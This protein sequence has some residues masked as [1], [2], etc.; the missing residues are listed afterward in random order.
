M[1]A[2]VNLTEWVALQGVAY[3]TAWPVSKAARLQGANAELGSPVEE[4]ESKHGRITPEGVGRHFAVA[5]APPS[6]HDLIWPTAHQEP[7]PP[8]PWQP[9]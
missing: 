9:R 3:V 1:N 7:P 6:T 5:A 8:D 2:D 4:Y